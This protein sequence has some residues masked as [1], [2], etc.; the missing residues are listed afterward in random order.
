MEHLAIQTMM[1]RIPKSDCNH[2]FKI[3]KICNDCSKNGFI[4]LK[5]N[6]KNRIGAR[7]EPVTRSLLAYASTDCQSYMERYQILMQIKTI[8]ES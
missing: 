4:K 3:F 7:F 8:N 6:K 2:G 5:R 1:K